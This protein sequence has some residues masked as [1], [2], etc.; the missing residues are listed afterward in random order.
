MGIVLFKDGFIM[1]VNS[2]FD[3]GHT[4]IADFDGVSVDDFILCR[5]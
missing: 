3:V 4:G 1:P 2:L 5:A